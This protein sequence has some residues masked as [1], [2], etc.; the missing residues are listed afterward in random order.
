[1]EIVILILFVLYVLMGAGAY[2]IRKAATGND[3]L[4]IVLATWPFMLCVHAFL[5]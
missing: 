3:D 4:V 5:N 2:K 1:M